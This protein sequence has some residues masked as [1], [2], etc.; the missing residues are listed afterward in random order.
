MILVTGATGT[1]G[2][3]VVA[4]LAA[5]RAPF[6]ALVRK[7][8]D[9]ARLARDGVAAVV[10]DLADQASLDRALAGVQAVFALTAP[11]PA[12]PQLLGNLI[13]ASKRAGVGRVVLQSSIG[14]APHASGS[15][16]RWNG[17]AERVLQESGVPHVIL[18]PNGFMQ[19]FVAYYAQAVVTAGKIQGYAGTEQ[20]SVID[21]RDIADV[22]AAC[23]EGAASD[24]DVLDLTGP[25][26]HAL[27]EQCAMLS[28]RLGRIVPFVPVTE[29]QA[30]R[31]MTERGTP[32]AIAH[33]VIGL[34]HAYKTGI[35]A[36][37]TGTVERIAGHP[38]RSFGDY[39]DENLAAF[40]TR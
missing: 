24:G 4:R 14:A 19:N 5:A 1:V 40:K 13:V 22:A 18:R 12:L 32:P 25:L 2:G 35:G 26:P 34:Q 39:L 21:A 10:G 6:R 23:L 37:V 28:M 9:V 15:F 27:A 36:I 3:A 33:A 20:V 8:D 29:A 16:L 30:Y 11:S 7:P 17:L 31:A 38:A